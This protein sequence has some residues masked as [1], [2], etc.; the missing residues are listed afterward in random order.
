MCFLNKINKLLPLHITLHQ[1]V[2]QIP[3]KIHCGCFMTK[4][5]KIQVKAVYIHTVMIAQEI[6]INCILN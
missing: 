1:S 4:C 2:I 5:K 6:A 3:S